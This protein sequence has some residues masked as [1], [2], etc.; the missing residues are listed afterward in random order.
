MWAV[1]G[2]AG[3]RVH[4]DGGEFGECADKL[5]L[6]DNLLDLPPQPRM[7]M[8]LNHRINRIHIPSNL[9]L[10]IFLRFPPNITLILRIIFPLH[11]LLLNRKIE[12]PIFQPFYL[13]VT[14]VLFAVHLGLE[15][16]QA[17]I[18]FF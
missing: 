14:A 8:V 5:G 15:G 12:Q 13:I 10:I 18:G 16:C 7:L 17:F 11:N 2:I 9:L 4:G 6:A 1:Q 3:L